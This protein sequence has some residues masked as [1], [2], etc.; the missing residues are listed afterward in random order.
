MKILFWLLTVS[1]TPLFSFS[2]SYPKDYFANP[3]DTPFLLAGTFGEIRSD[4]FHSGIDFSTSEEVGKQVF[5]A[6]DGYISRIKISA[7]GFGKALYITHPNGFVTVYGHLKKFSP[8]IEK[9]VLEKQYEIESFEIELF[10]PANEFTFKKGEVIA[11][12]GNTGSST[13]P[14]LHFEIRDEKTEEPLNPMLFGFVIPDT[15]GPAI[16][17]LRI[18]SQ[19]SSNGIVVTTSSLNH[20]VNKTGS[21]MF[22]ISPFDTIHVNGKTGFEFQLDD[23]QY[24][25]GSALGIYSMELKIDSTTI[26]S[27][28]FDRFSFSD[29][30]YANAHIDY[31]EKQNEGI[32]FERCYRLPGNRMKIYGDTTGWFNFYENRNYS[33]EAK[34]GRAHV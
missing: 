21:G 18:A 23:F 2:Q 12:S 4:H 1:V 32:T 20:K 15:V 19:Q 29:T 8:N 6:A 24:R 27:Y 16:T 14:H 25:S 28:K 9:Y 26:Y 22:Q 11:Y 34:I 30:R 33:V 3:I 5:A 10:P 7:I 31:E 13:G 17:S